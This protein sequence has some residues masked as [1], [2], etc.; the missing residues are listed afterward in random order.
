MRT[1]RTILLLVPAAL[2]G[3]G[4]PAADSQRLELVRTV[5]LDGA[6]GRLDHM[7]IDARGGRLF[8]DRPG[9]GGSP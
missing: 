9:G 8:A 2:T 7:A 1:L 5:Q 4:L 3:A 6:E